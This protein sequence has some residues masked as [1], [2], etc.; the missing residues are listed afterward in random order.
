MLD[1][2]DDLR[3]TLV[4]VEGTEVTAGCV[5][6]FLADCC[7]QR[8]VVDHLSH[9]CVDGYKQKKSE[10][11]VV[12]FDFSSSFYYVLAAFTTIYRIMLI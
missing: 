12:W 10:E 2:G 6:R 3:L 7:M 11:D 4:E 8:L 1:G 9:L 5:N